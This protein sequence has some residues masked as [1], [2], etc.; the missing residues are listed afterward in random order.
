MKIWMKKIFLPLLILVFFSG[1]GGPEKKIVGAW[2]VD[3]EEIFFAF[4]NHEDL[5]VN[6][7]IFMKYTLTK[8][9]KIILGEQEPAAFKMKGDTIIITQPQG[10]TINLKRIKKPAF[11]ILKE[12][13]F[14]TR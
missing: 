11:E 2:K 14:K 7:Q 9:G 12:P 13:K 1:C 8:D 6:N 5:N 10:F 3:G 4:L